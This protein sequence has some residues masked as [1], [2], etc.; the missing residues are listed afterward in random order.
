MLGFKGLKRIAMH[1]LPYRSL[2]DEDASVTVTILDMNALALKMFYNSLNCHASKLLEKVSDKR[3][4]FIGKGLIPLC[5][6]SLGCHAALLLFINFFG[7]VLCV[8]FERT[9]FP[10]G[11]LFC[12]FAFLLIASFPFCLFDSLRLCPFLFYYD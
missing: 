2:I 4:Y 5:S 6:Y 9:A 10:H 8:K 3:S 11:L 12:F 7:G 1:L